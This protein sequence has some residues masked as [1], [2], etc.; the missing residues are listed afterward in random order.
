MTELI[1]TLRNKATVARKAA[2]EKRQDAHIL[3]GLARGFEESILDIQKMNG[4]AKP[5]RKAKRK[6]KK[7]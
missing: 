2:Q 4:A 6:T 1:N 7:K 5:K 3:E